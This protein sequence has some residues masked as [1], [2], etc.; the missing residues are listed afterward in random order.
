MIIEALTMPLAAGLLNLS[1][2]VVKCTP[3]RAPAIYVKPMALPTKYNHRSTVAELSNR[4]TDTIS[5]Y[6]KHAITKT[7]GITSSQIEMRTQMQF[8]LENYETLG[9]GCVY[10]DRVEVTLK[11][12]PTVYVARDYSKRSCHYR[13]VL[14]HEKKHVTIDKQILNKYARKIGEALRLSVNNVPG[15]GPYPLSHLPKIQQDMQEYVASV[16]KTQQS[17]MEEERFRAQQGVDSLDEY[18]RIRL[19]CAG[20]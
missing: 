12:D 20:E 16:V 4:G 2:D 17:L 10:F 7:G 9:I 15:R 6:P 11:L 19:A 8:Q 5:P 14:K 1:A 18:E 3:P 13:E